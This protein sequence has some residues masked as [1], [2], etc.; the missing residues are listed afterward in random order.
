LLLLDHI[1]IHLIFNI[2]SII[3]ANTFINCA[4][5]IAIIILFSIFII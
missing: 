4:I 3:V 1:I 5:F 2:F